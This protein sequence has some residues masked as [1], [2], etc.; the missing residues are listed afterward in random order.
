MEHQHYPAVKVTISEIVQGVIKQEDQSQPLHI[1]TPSGEKVYR[2]NI[3][4]TILNLEKVG[5][6]TNV[7]IDDGSGQIIVRFFEE[8]SPSIKLAVG[9]CFLL[10]GKAR[11]YNE[12]KYIS[13]EIMKE[14]SPLWLKARALEVAKRKS[15]TPLLVETVE[16]EEV[17]KE[18]IAKE[19]ITAESSLFPSQRI[20]GLIKELDQGSG[21]LVEEVIHKSSLKET[22]QL[23]QAMLEKGEIFQIAPGKIKVL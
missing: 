20:L 7:L 11:I 21:V 1:L 6:I 22:E 3:M 19:E 15:I 2:C 10:N 16:K 4:A 12:E 9:K 23:L 17:A 13:P 14:I 8:V 5:S 18:E